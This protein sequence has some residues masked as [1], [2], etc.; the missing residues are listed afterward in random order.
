MTEPKAGRLDRSDEELLQDT[1]KGDLR[2]FD[3]IVRRYRDRLLNFAF[4]YLGDATT[5]EDVV[6]ETFLRAFRKK[7]E[8]RAT[9]R[10]STWLFTVAGNLA[11]NELR[12][13]KRW[14]FTSLGWNEDAEQHIEIPDDRPQ[15]DTLA[16]T[17]IATEAIQEAIE[18]LPPSH[19]QAVILSDIQGLAYEEIAQIVGCPLGTVKSRINRGRLRLQKKLTRLGY[20][21]DSMTT[22]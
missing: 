6:Q 2:A 5:A 14:R 13:R 10:F 18:S 21:P 3:I 17:E 19:R 12:R 8:Y 15:P 1:I 16:E 9:A 7:E 4:R 22:E 20:L 11:K